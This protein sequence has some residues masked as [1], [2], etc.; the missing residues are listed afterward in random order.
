MRYTAECNAAD[1]KT[2]IIDEAH[3]DNT[4]ARHMCFD[5]LMNGSRHI[6]HNALHGMLVWT[7]LGPSIPKTE[8]SSPPKKCGASEGCT[9]NGLLLK[10][11]R[12]CCRPTWANR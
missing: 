11:L 4:S 9:A 7:I 1:S 6:I 8:P 5:V 3:I 2:Y 10:G 12:Q